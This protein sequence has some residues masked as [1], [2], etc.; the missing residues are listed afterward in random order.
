MSLIA[1]KTTCSVVSQCAVEMPAACPGSDFSSGRL[2]VWCSEI[3]RTAAAARAP[4]LPA[5]SFA[6]RC[7][8]VCRPPLQF[9]MWGRWLA[10]WQQNGVFNQV[11]VTASA[12]L[13]D[14]A[15]NLLLVQSSKLHCGFFFAFLLAS[16]SVCLR[17]RECACSL[18]R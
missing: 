15:R 8:C 18:H 3:C 5:L 6:L 1:G 4:D 9:R 7:R 11:F 10:A 13:Q 2:E 16:Q 17:N 12:T 14:Q